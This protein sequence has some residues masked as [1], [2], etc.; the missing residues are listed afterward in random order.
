MSRP[1][2]ADKADAMCAAT[3]TSALP[4]HGPLMATRLSYLGCR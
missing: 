3:S 4:T 1:A 2:W